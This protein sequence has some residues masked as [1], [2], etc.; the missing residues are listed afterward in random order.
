MVL[1]GRFVLPHWRARKGGPTNRVSFGL[2][3]ACIGIAIVFA[4]VG[5]VAWA[6]VYGYTNRPGWVGVTD[7]Q[8]WDW[9]KLLAVPF[10]VGAGG[11]IVAY[12]FT[13]S[14]NRTTQLIEEQ[15]TQDEALQAYLDQMGKLLLEKNLRASKEISEVRN[16]ARAQTLAVLGRLNSDRKRTVI[17]FLYETILINAGDRD[18]GDMPFVPIY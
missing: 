7:K 2:V 8:L 1:T 15:R 10:V 9:L 13:R 4:A 14:E 17:V 3:L 18:A 16:V 6:T 11:P 5:F 12:L